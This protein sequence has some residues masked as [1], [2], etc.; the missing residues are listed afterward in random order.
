MGAGREKVPGILEQV[1]PDYWWS[2]IEV[3]DD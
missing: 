3:K 2:P 1:S